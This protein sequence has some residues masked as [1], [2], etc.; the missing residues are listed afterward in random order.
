MVDDAYLIDTNVLVYYLDGDIPGTNRRIDAIF[1][2]SFVVSVI[3]KIEFLGWSNYLTHPDELAV[4]KT[5]IEEATVVSLTDTI[6][7]TVIDLRRKH[8]TRLPDCII[9]ATALELGA[10]LV[11]RN[12][13]DFEGMSV[14][15][16]DPFDLSTT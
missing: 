13:Q 6:V 7:E 15:L 5:F 12:T 8:R 4:A 14:P 1:R 9:A 11:T 3:S 10:T 16:Y 2:D